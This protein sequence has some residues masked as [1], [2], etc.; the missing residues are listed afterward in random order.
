MK[1]FGL[2]LACFIVGAAI[3]MLVIVLLL[4]VGSRRER[5]K[6]ENPM[7]QYERELKQF[8]PCLTCANLRDWFPDNDEFYNFDC[9]KRNKGFNVAPLL[10]A[11]YKER[12]DRGTEAEA[13]LAEKEGDA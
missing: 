9:M 3:G 8:P 7:E 2:C 10:C 4:S 5:I 1:T 11:D 13:A 6:E 12:E